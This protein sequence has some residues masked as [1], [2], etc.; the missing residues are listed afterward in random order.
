MA[1]HCDMAAT[2]LCIRLAS[3]L[4]ALSGPTWVGEWNSVSIKLNHCDLCNLIHVSPFHL[5]ILSDISRASRKIQEV[6]GF[7]E[8]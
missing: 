1:V 3:S 4:S 8:N 5:D 2:W 7:M 6:F